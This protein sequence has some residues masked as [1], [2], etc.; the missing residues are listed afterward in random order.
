MSRFARER[1][2]FFIEEADRTDICKPGLRLHV[3]DRS[4]V[5]VVTVLTTPMAQT[6]GL[7]KNLHAVPRLKITDVRLV[8]LRVL[9]ETGKMEATPGFRLCASGRRSLS[10]DPYRSVI[11]RHRAGFGWEVHG[12]HVSGRPKRNFL[13]ALPAFSGRGHGRASGHA[14]RAAGAEALESAGAPGGPG[15]CRWCHNGDDQSKTI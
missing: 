6:S 8:A 12:E 11:D 9:R 15:R 2:V 3:C 10:R 1:R 7:P 4:Q 13:I 5:R 14:D